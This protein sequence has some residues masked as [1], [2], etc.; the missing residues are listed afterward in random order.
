[1]DERNPDKQTYKHF[2]AEEH[3]VLVDPRTVTDDT[4]KNI[5]EKVALRYAAAS[6]GVKDPIG[7]YNKVSNQKRSASSSDL[8]ARM[9]GEKPA[10]RN[11][12]DASI[13]AA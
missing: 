8:I 6:R 13:F 7:E 3:D 5:Y 9:S 4:V 11:N 12:T 10:K 2:R 1:M